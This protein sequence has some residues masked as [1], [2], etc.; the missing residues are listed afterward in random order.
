MPV[1]SQTSNIALR[2]A[3]APGVARR[4]QPGE[5]GVPVGAGI[6]GFNSEAEML[7][8]RARIDI[9]EHAFG[10]LNSSE[11]K[12]EIRGSLHCA[13]NDEA[14]RCFGRDDVFL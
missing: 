8:T 6:G 9:F 2:S 10:H 12:Y 4:Q 11:D 3:G 5:G 14:V 13:A 1:S 7:A